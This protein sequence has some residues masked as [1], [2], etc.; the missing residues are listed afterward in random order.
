MKIWTNAVVAGGVLGIAVALKKLIH[1][2][3]APR[4]A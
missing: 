2:L 3:R 4:F 1:A